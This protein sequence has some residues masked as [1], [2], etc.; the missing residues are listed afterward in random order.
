ML[1][2]I[3]ITIFGEYIV[4][5]YLKMP[6]ERGPDWHEV[7]NFGGREG[8]AKEACTDFGEMDPTRIQGLVKKYNGRR[9]YRRSPGNYAPQKNSL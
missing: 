6:D 8:D 1:T 3:S 7:M 2:S 4:E 5:V 9:M